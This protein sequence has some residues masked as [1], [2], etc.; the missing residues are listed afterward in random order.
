[1]KHYEGQQFGR[2]LVMERTDQKKGYC[3]LWRCLCNCGNETLADSYALGHG[4]KQS[5]GCLQ[6]ES[7]RQKLIGR[8][9][10][11]L[12]VI[13]DTEESKHSC[14]IWECKCECG[15]PNPVYIRTDSLTCGETESC[16]CL[17]IETARK[18]VLNARKNNL[19]DSTNVGAIK[20]T[21]LHSKPQANNTSGVKGVSWHRRIKK[22]VARIGFQ[23]KYIHLGYFIDIEDAKLTRKRAE[24]R[25][26]GEYLDQHQ[27]P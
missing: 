15:N 26:F 4:T 18:Q 21:L 24:E 12:T 13:R 8:K 22:W 11:R 6:E 5:C 7:R 20:E 3:Y 16:G 10:G 1:M 19:V 23:G 9:F 14:T 17:H 25:Y 27:N 2:L